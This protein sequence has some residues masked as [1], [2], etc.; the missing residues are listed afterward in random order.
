MTI[1]KSNSTNAVKKT[2]LNNKLMES[3]VF[4]QI[5]ELELEENQNKQNTNL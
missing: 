4:T 3:N 5:N 1:A 2:T